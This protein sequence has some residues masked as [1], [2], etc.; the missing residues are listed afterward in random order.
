MSDTLDTVNNLSMQII[1]Y[2]G[3]AHEL[4]EEALNEA[5]SGKFEECEKKMKEGFGKLTEAHKVQTKMIQDAIEEEDPKMPVLF[6]HAQDTMMTIQSEYRMAKRI[7]D[8]YKKVYK[9][10]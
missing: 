8:L 1:L 2:S 7:V 10:D 9:N 4:F 6:I 5:G 3:D